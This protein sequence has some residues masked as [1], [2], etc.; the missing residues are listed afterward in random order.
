MLGA[1][2]LA[3]S[4]TACGS[5]GSPGAQVGAPTTITDTAAVSPI[6]TGCA[7]AA[8]QAL[9][10]VAYRVYRESAS[11]RIIAEAIQR[12]SS[13]RALGQ[14]VEGDDPAATLRALRSLL[15]NQI[16]SVRVTRGGR[17]LAK[18]ERGAGIAPA[19]G[20]ILNAGGQ[21]VG[22]FTVSVQ[23]ANGYSQTVSGLLAAQVVVRSGARQLATTLHPAPALKRG[24][25][26]V[27]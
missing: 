12:L 21:T 2:L 3:L 20:P 9:E 13:S 26:E 11:G 1:L 24:E 27:S 17:T 23:G 25:G 8:L 10:Q 7:S 19:S 16:V 18:I 22:E 5:S 4:L 6:A 14:A 15:L